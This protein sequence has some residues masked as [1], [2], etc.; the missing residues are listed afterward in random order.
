V[1]FAL[2]FFTGIFS[3]LM[4]PFERGLIDFVVGR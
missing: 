3:R 4:A 2:V 1:L